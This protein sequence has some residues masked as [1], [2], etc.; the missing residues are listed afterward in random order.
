MGIMHEP[1]EDALGQGRIA[2]LLMPASE[3]K[4]A[5]QDRGAELVAIFADFEEVATLG[6]GQ[7]SHG[8]IIHHEHIDLG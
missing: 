4:L 2:D 8:P 6:F 3:G 1:V 7:R 5:S